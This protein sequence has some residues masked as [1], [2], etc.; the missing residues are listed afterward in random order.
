MV[1]DRTRRWQRSDE[2]MPER[3]DP[4]IDPLHALRGW[5]LAVREFPRDPEARRRLR[6][7]AAEQGLWEALALLLTDEAHAAD[8]PEVAAAFFEELADVYENLDQPLE[9]ITA[10]EAVIAHDPG[11]AEHL[12]RLAWLYRR[13]GAW[14]K[15]AEM[16]EQV[17]EL[18]RDERARAALRAAATLYREHGRLDRA[19]SIYRAIVERKPGDSA[20]WRALD[21]VLAELGRWREVAEVRG[22]RCTLTTSG[23]EKAAL[24]RSQ[25]RALEQAG[26]LAAAAGVVAEASQHAP[27]DVSGLVDYAD[28]LARSGQGREAAEILAARVGDAVT[29]GART[30]DIAAL[31]LRLAGILDESCSDRAAATT[32]LE[33]LLVDAP[34]FMPA[35]ERITA[36]A[37]QTADPRLHADALLRY[38]AALPGTD[39]PA[40][41]IA[42]A[43]RYR[44]A[45]D[46]RAAVRAFEDASELI[47][48]DDAV[49]EE[50]EDARAAVVVERAAADATS[51]PAA[52]E[53]RL[54]AVLATRPHHLDA[55]LALVELLAGAR[56]LDEAAEHLRDTL[57][58]APD[59]VQKPQLAPLVH[60]YALAMAA[61]GEPDEAHQLLHE[62]HR[63]DRKHLVITLALGESCFA[64]RLWREA[65]RHLATLAEHPDAGKHA[66]PVALGLVH[67]AQAEVRGL[68]PANAGALYEAAIRIDPKCGPA[69]HALAEAA[70]ERGDLERAAECLEREA[71]AAVEPRD[72]LRLFDALGDMALDV[73]GDPARAER[74]WRQVLEARHVP[75]LDKS[76]EGRTRSGAEGAA[77]VI[78][79]LLALQRKRGATFERGETCERLGEVV[80]DERRK[81]M[82]FEEAADAYAA[83][84]DLVRARELA[85]RLIASHPLDVDVVACASG[86]A[87]ALGDSRRAAQWL[88]RALGAWDAA[89]D[90]GD[91]DP[92]RAD[93]WRRLGDAE[94]ALGNEEPAR[95]AYRRA[96]S[97]APDSEGAL[98]ARRGVVE[99]AQPDTATSPHALQSSLF[100]LVEVEQDPGDT[101]ALARQ[102]QRDRPDDARAT[103]ELARALGAVLDEADDRF[104]ADHPA[105]LMASDQG[106]G[107]PLDEDDR[108]ELVDDPGDAPLGDLLDTLGEAAALLC[109]DSTTALVDAD[110]A[111]A[112]RVPASTQAAALALYPQ[113]AK[114][115]GGPATLMYATTKPTVELALLL[116]A[117]PIVVLGPKLASVRAQSR[118]ELEL[119]GPISA[120]GDAVLRF[121]LGRIVELARPRRVFAAGS[122]RDTFTRLVAGLTAFTNPAAGDAAEAERLRSKLSVALRKRLADQLAAL[123]SRSLDAHAYHAACQR[124]ADRAGLLACGDTAIAIEL[125]GG[126]TKAR[127][128][129]RLASTKRYLEARR[130]LRRG[131]V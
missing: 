3:S 73:L 51:D 47:P 52:S 28:V 68:R 1:D 117:P 63:L 60:R 84:G 26:E 115:L 74:C 67:A 55:N 122:S 102:L 30:D 49:R 50:L 6:A 130:K 35:L 34:A 54:R 18:S 69:W 120:A 10:M 108:R 123:P 5:I 56:R 66:Q 107:A 80:T 77:K 22:E 113:I 11:N 101:L 93:L 27:E 72:R 98:A 19:A 64:R 89:G 36:Y 99:L 48:D 86:I 53:R 14:A 42:A 7:L 131:T 4:H 24:L 43:R 97:A 20:A 75:V 126:V 58:S 128:L 71:V 100:A 88:R 104:L 61:L 114:M 21:D 39:R 85:E 57:A 91:E 110:L 33:E 40:V 13:A 112:R 83:G 17:G 92:R 118:S 87:G 29:R 8:K 109:P 116:A 127:H 25:A 59:T 90:R 129:V 15:A 106:Y 2:W 16:F 62:A 81:K 12:D 65:A 38:A 31:R 95:L 111:D 32:V 76:A 79:K 94:R 78:E 9:V 41:V 23:V 105:P 119:S 124:A 96:V 82:L 103:F 70:I 44:A 125:A 121:R 45:R 37:A 46:H